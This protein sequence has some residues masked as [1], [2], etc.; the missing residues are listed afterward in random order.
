MDYGDYY[1]GICIGTT[2]GIHS[3]LHPLAALRSPTSRPSKELDSEAIRMPFLG[4][5]KKP[6][7]GRTNSFFELLMGGCQN[8][9]PFLGPYYS[10][11]PII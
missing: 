3:L 8:Y 6:G 2:V 7:T 10:A 1:W 4:V 11:A 5:H 9:G